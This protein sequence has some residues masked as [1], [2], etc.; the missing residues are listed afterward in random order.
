MCTYNIRLDDA[1]LQRVRPL[2]NGEEAMQMWI[3]KQLHKALIA[4]T[5]QVERK[6]RLDTEKEELLQ[7]I[8]ALKD[9]T[10]GLSALAGI[11][12]NPGPNF[13]WEEL[14]DEALAE[15]YGN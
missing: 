8:D 14:R 11:L 1:V 10:K 2:F 13:S 7:R 12:G 15:K 5:N 4:Y 3:E 6:E 9:G